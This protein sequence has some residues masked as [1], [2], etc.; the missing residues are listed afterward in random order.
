[1]LEEVKKRHGE[2][3]YKQNYLMLEDGT[4]TVVILEVV[5]QFNNNI[6]VG[7]TREKNH[8]KVWFERKLYYKK[9]VEPRFNV[10]YKAYKLKDFRKPELRMPIQPTKMDVYNYWNRR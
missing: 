2:G 8:L 9:Q 4:T 3:F 5:Y 7:Y 10:G 6:V 1:M